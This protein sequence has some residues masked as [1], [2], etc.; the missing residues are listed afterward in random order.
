MNILFFVKGVVGVFLGLQLFKEG[1]QMGSNE[2]ITVFEALFK[3]FLREPILK[4][5]NKDPRSCR[6]WFC[7]TC[8]DAQAPPNPSGVLLIGGHSMPC[9]GKGS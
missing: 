3:A 8:R 2:T 5:L 4:T 7:P 9:V 6:N 1:F